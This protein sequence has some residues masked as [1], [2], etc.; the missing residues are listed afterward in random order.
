[1]SSVANFHRDTCSSLKT[2]TRKQMRICRQNVEHME[3]VHAGAK[4]A[5]YECQYQFRNRPWNCT[6]LPRDTIFGKV[7]LLDSSSTRFVFY[8]LLHFSGTRES[9]FVHAISAA[10][11][12]YSVTKACS[13]GKYS[14]CGCDN[15]YRGMSHTGGFQWAG[16]SDNIPYG[17][18]FSR[19]F[20][21][22]G[23]K[24]KKQQSQARL[25]MNLHNNEAGRK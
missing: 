24:R 21:D 12:A 10:G 25:Q 4:L 18:A 14:K 2:L 11:V 7:L 17:L 22:A 1:M 19:R 20:V 16:C 23:E 8:F 6:V 3:N 15:N 9:A 13:S 5:I